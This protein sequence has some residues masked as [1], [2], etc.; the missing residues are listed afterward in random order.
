[1]ADYRW[2]E[3]GKRSLIGK[4]I[5]RLDG[6]VKSSG[7]VKYTYD[8]D[9]PNMLYGKMVLSPY[10]QATIKSI[11]TSAAEKMPGV[12]AVQVMREPGTEILWAGQEVVA[13]AAE[14]EERRAH[15]LTPVTA[16]PRM[17]A[18]GCK[19]KTPRPERQPHGQATTDSTWDA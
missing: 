11:D 19:K 15:G 8:V 18:S 17:A 7:R 5:S 12:K 2:P 16:T 10:A 1:M 14:S 3:A 9:R 6:P 4:R 13:V